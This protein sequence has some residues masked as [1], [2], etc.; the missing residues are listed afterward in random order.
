[1]WFMKFIEILDTGWYWYT[2]RNGMIMGFSG[3]VTMALDAN[4]PLCLT[5]NLHNLWLFHS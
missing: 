5:H 4:L 1:M 2:P 3:M